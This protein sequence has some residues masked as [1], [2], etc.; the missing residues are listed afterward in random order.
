[1]GVSGGVRLTV[2][3][4]VLIDSMENIPG[5]RS[6]SAEYTIP[7]AG[8]PV[9]L[10]I[11]GAHWTGQDKAL[12]FNWFLTEGGSAGAVEDHSQIFSSGPNAFAV[13]GGNVWNIEHYQNKDFS[14]DP[15]GLDIHVADG[16]SYNYNQWEPNPG[17][18]PDNWSSRW[19]R[20]VDFPAGSYTFTFRV[21]D[22]GR[23]LVDGQEII[24]HPVGQPDNTFSGT[25]TLTEGRHTIVVEHTDFEG[26]E[27][28][29]LTWDPPVG[30]MLWPD[31]CNAH[32]THSLPGNAELC[33]NRGPA[34]IN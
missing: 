34:T 32:F 12:H 28:I 6:L 3:N 1:V 31:G 25:V 26:E 24:N 18:Y 20:T 27:F 8:A 9:A 19:T 2:N 11:E 13:D 21:Q 7:T 23:V 4:E 5:F 30:T 29:F 22:R 17:I 33:P 14:G 10:A 16:I 15:I